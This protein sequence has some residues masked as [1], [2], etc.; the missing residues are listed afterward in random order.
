MVVVVVV[1][2]WPAGQELGAHADVEEALQLQVNPRPRMPWAAAAAFADSMRRRTSAWS[3]A[4]YAEDLFRW[5]S[6]KLEH[7]QEFA[8]I[9][10][11]DPVF[12]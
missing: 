12:C 8:K 3:A 9:Y 1:C 7:L 6:D 4:S 2:G 11:T 5:T 10:L